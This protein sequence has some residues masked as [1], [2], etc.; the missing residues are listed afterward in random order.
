MYFD[1]PPIFEAAL[2]KGEVVQYGGILRDAATKQIVKHLKPADLPVESP[3]EA[4][5]QV[6]ASLKNPWAIGGGILI[7]AVGGGIAVAVAA[8]RNRVRALVERYNMSL[9]AYLEAARDGNLDEDMLAK[10]VGAL[11]SVAE[12]SKAGQIK[13]VHSAEQV[14]ALLKFASDYTRS[15][16][17]A[18]SVN[19]TEALNEELTVGG[20]SVVDLRHYLEVQR[21]IFRRAA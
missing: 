2:A 9:I 12:L 21:Q 8:R 7:L 5:A 1:I 20:G 16:A 4:V 18:N 6:A 10:L 11:D 19:L 13:V 17:E 15:L 14:T 3:T